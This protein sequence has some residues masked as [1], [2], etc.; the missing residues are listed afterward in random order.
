MPMLLQQLLLLSTN[1]GATTVWTS[2]EAGQ[3]VKRYVFK[4]QSFNV[5]AK[6]TIGATTWYQVG[7]DEWINGKYVS[8]STN[9]TNIVLTPDYADGAVTVWAT[10]AYTQPT[11][12]YL[13]DNQQVNAV[14]KHVVGHETWYQLDNGGWVP[15]RYVKVV[16]G[17]THV[18]PLQ[19]ATQ[20]HSVVLHSS[21]TTKATTN[22]NVTSQASQT[23]SAVQ[24]T[25]T[26]ASQALHS[27]VS[28]NN[29]QATT[30]VTSA[31]ASQTAQSAAVSTA[32][33]QVVISATNK[34][35]QAASTAT[36][37]TA[38]KQTQ[39][40]NAA[41]GI[42]PASYIASQASQTSVASTASQTTIQ[43]KASQQVIVSATNKTSQVAQ[44]AASTAKPA[45]SVASQH[46]V[47]QTA[48]SQAP[49]S[50]ANK[51]SQVAQSMA[52]STVKPTASVASQHVVSQAA[53]SQAPASV[54]NK[55]SQV[56][57]SMAT[58][59]AKPATSAA[60]QHQQSQ[61]QATN[62]SSQAATT[63]QTN[64]NAVAAV[65]KCAEEQLGK[66]YVTGGKGPNGF[67]CSGLMH[68]VFLHGANKEIGG[69]TVPQESAGTHISVADAQ[70]G[71]LLFWGTPGNTYHDALY[72]GNGEYIAAPKPGDVVDVEHISSYFMPSF[73]V[74][75]L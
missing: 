8:V 47:S 46:V 16:N 42:A 70:P 44:S 58:S 7:Q 9:N 12:Q 23:T 39:T 32:P 62:S 45:A 72:I 19:P 61:A 28:A 52:T 41:N 68:Y 54:A 4:N 57:Q 33:K 56:A 74:R 48:A 30:K 40:T 71:D 18:A 5:L 24:K 1:Q 13:T 37:V 49:A 21:I 27:A 53:A 35:S 29:Q 10:P 43:S 50:V 26:V 63:T 64:T 66:P 55:T 25:T 73:A 34:T 2:P 75:V 20:Q 69:W 6:K 11:G 59:T 65:I 51:T 14:A 60:S 15:A 67:D 17:A 36:S 22:A 38:T 3:Q 31:V